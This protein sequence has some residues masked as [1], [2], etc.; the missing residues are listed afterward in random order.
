MT[1]YPV[2]CKSTPLFSI[3]IPT[4]NSG[5]T[6]VE[7]LNSI[8]SQTLQD[9]E[10]IVQDCLSSDNTLLNISIFSSN[11]HSLSLRVFEEADL[12]VY[13]A[14]NKALVRARG[15]WIYF[16]G[17][18]DKFFEPTTLESVSKSIDDNVD[19][20]YGDVCSPYFGGRYDG[21]FSPYMLYKKNICHQSIFFRSFIFEKHGHFNLSFKVAAD[22]EHNLRWYLDHT[23]NALYI[24][25]VIASFADGGL[26]ST[27]ADPYF[28]SQ[29]PFLYVYHGRKVLSLRT[30]VG[31]LLNK[32]FTSLKR[33][34]MRDILTAFKLSVYL[35]V[36]STR[37]VR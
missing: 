29:K 15:M 7:C 32:L 14:M 37:L 16:L 23:I 9:F 34:D 36:P 8:A 2:N 28:D 27:T 22:W 18:D 12:G 26:S 31:L 1:I 20:I 17:S 35:L 25:Q 30:K 21:S 11:H 33:R 5:K 6:I 10:V 4:Y 19:V 24:D 3:I 13:D